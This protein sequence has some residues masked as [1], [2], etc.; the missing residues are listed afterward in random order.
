MLL[1]PIVVVFIIVARPV[2]VSAANAWC[3]CNAKQRWCCCWLLLLLLLQVEWHRLRAIV[4][5]K[6]RK[7]DIVRSARIH[8]NKMRNTNNNKKRTYY[9]L[10]WQDIIAKV[11]QLATCLAWRNSFPCSLL[12]DNFIGC[13]I[14]CL[15]VSEKASTACR[16]LLLLSSI[17]KALLLHLHKNI[18]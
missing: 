1:M 12:C 7:K 10:K 6:K 13:N 11:R 2:K 3:K 16:L 18:V 15:G 5:R 9:Y 8:D 14:K 17:W 4:S